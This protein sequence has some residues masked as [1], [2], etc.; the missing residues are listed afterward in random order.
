MKILSII[1]LI[2]SVLGALAIFTCTIIWGV[3]LPETAL[4]WSGGPVSGWV[5]LIIISFCFSAF[6]LLPGI[7]A[8]DEITN[9]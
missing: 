7:I 6:T 2:V 4:L 3:N 9:E 5:E 8:Y 1:S